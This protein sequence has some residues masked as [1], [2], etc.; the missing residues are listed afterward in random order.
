MA[1]AV[2]PVVV[3][4][5][6]AQRRLHPADDDGHLAVRLM[7]AVAVDD[8]GAVG[9]QTGLAAGGVEVL[10][11][12][13]FGCGVVVDHGIDVAR[14]DHE[15]VLRTTEAHEIRCIVKIRLAEHAHAVARVLQHARDDGVAKRGVIDVRV[16]RDHHKIRLLPA[17]REHLLARHRQKLSGHTRPP[18]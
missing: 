11:A 14:G 1:H 2:A 8:G 5:E 7:D 15:A 12:G 6:P 10:R 18:C 16:P 9:A 3:V 17:P 13:L 4:R